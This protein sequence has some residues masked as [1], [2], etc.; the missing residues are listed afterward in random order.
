MQNGDPV[1]QFLFSSLFVSNILT[2]RCVKFA[3]RGIK[4]VSN[5]ICPRFMSIVSKVK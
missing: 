4:Q 2:Y 3:V 5:R 1:P